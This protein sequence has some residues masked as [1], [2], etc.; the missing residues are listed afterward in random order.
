[1][2]PKK[3]RKVTR[4]FNRYRAPECRVKT[5]KNTEKELVV[6][7][8]GTG[9]SFYCCYDENFIDYLYYLKDHAGKS[10]KIQ[11]VKETKPGVFLVVYKPGESDP[12]TPNKESNDPE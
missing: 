10:F 11:E 12:G 2:E 3:L 5:V 8:E 7:F 9:A 6:R 4:E 1:M